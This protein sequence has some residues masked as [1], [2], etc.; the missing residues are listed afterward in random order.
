MTF[1]IISRIV[2]VWHARWVHIYGGRIQGTSS[3]PILIPLCGYQKCTASL[4]GD[5][6]MGRN[7]R[8]RASK[9]KQRG[10]LFICLNA[11]IA[12]QFEFIQHNWLNNGPLQRSLR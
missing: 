2:S 9:V 5:G 11:D 8:R 7:G 4:G 12:G 1:S 6:P 10:M 3:A